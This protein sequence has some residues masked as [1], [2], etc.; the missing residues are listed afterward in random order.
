MLFSTNRYLQPPQQVLADAVAPCERGVVMITFAGCLFGLLAVLALAVDSGKAFKSRLI[1]QTGMDAAALAGARVL[2][3]EGRGQTAKAL[4]AAKDALRVNLEEN[5]PASAQQIDSFV[6]S[7]TGT[8]A[9]NPEPKGLTYKV[10]TGNNLEIETY[11]FRYLPGTATTF[12]ISTTAEAKIRSAAVHIIVDT[13]ASMRC[14]VDEVTLQPCDCG[15]AS[16]SSTPCDLPSA[17]LTKFQTAINNFIQHF[18]E[19]N[20]RVGVVGFNTAARLFVPINEARGFSKSQVQ[21]AISG[22]KP[23]GETN[24]CDGFFQAYQDLAAKKQQGNA[25]YVVVSDGSPDVGRFQFAHPRSPALDG[26]SY[27]LWDSFTRC[28]LQPDAWPVPDGAIEADFMPSKF[29]S[30]APLNERGP[31]GVQDLLYE[32]DWVR[33]TP[34]DTNMYDHAAPTWEE[35]FTARV[36]GCSG[37]SCQSVWNP[38]SSRTDRL[39]SCLQDVSF[40]TFLFSENLEIPLVWNDALRKYQNDVPDDSAGWW[41]RNVYDGFKYRELFYDCALAMADTIRRDGGTIF[42]IALGQSAPA[43]VAGGNWDPYQ[44]VSDRYSRKDVY[45]RRLAFDPCGGAKSYTD[46]SDP[47]NVRRGDPFF[48]GFDTY[49]EMKDAGYNFGLALPVD[50]VNP[51]KLSSDLENFFEVI[52]QKIKTRLAS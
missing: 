8:L 31:L 13:S 39:K 51:A 35:W 17:K 37:L 3:V 26:S 43:P 52:A 5:N 19:A 1:V 29:Y 23:A 20:D 25:V 6:N 14:P 11:L 32:T 38:A 10:A 27:Y 40:Y 9:D 2:A 41:K 21:S 7:L 36:A 42:V 47:A 44:D 28:N 33:K 12:A 16:Q 22:L 46:P 24:L 15:L 45:L 30:A 4:S 18:D 34:P 49:G 50:P 48:F